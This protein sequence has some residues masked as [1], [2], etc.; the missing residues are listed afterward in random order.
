M[1]RKEYYITKR[2]HKANITTYAIKNYAQS[3]R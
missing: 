3:R 2:H 1:K